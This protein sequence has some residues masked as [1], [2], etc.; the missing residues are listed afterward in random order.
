MKPRATPFPSWFESIL[1]FLGMFPIIKETDRVFME[2][3]MKF[4]FFSLIAISLVACK[5]ASKR[6]S[7]MS[8]ENLPTK[9][10]VAIP[11]EQESGRSEELEITTP[12]PEEQL[13]LIESMTEDGVLV[14]EEEEEQL[15]LAKVVQQKATITPVIKESS[16]DGLY[17]GQKPGQGFLYVDKKDGLKSLNP[18]K[19]KHDNDKVDSPLFQISFQKTEPDTLKSD[20]EDGLL[21]KKKVLCTFKDNE[22]ARAYFKELQKNKRIDPSVKIV[23]FKL[24]PKQFLLKITKVLPTE[25]AQSWFKEKGFE[26]AEKE[27]LEGRTFSKEELGLLFP[28]YTAEKPLRFK[29]VSGKKS[30]KD[31]ETDVQNITIIL[32][33]GSTK[34]LLSPLNTLRLITLDDKVRDALV[35]FTKP[36]QNEFIDTNLYDFLRLVNMDK[37]KLSAYK[38]ASTDYTTRAISPSTKTTIGN[39]IKLADELKKFVAP[40]GRKTE[41]ANMIDTW[42]DAM[43]EDA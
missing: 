23:A 9:S 32:N 15:G 40:E 28:K 37:A 43:E 1:Q 41:F 3:K 19:V 33:A 38:A 35:A 20:L 7:F 24:G 34:A 42:R 5:Q 10:Q 31:I 16:P 8:Q 30:F 21:P 4:L 29:S 12:S 13:S 22:D 18:K 26:I 14:L 36:S 11:D 27:D 25:T 17:E 6:E 2:Q 39:A